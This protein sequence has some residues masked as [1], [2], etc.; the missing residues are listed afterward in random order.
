MTLPAL[1]KKVEEG[2][3]ITWLTC[4]DYPTAYMQE[5]AGVDMILVG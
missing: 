2:K 4:Y 5:Q 3:P 1:Y